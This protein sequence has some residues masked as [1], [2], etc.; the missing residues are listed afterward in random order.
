MKL[1]DDMKDLR[2]DLERRWIS[3]E[4]WSKFEVQARHLGMGKE[5]IAVKAAHIDLIERLDALVA[6]AEFITGLV[7]DDA[8]KPE[9][10]K[11]KGVDLGLSNA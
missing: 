7:V 9:K 11:P 5:L 3:P 4:E 10:E 8:V 2:D 1:L 6:K